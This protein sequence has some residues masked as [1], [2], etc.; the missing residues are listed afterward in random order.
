MRQEAHRIWHW[1]QWWA[2][3][4]KMPSGCQQFPQLLTDPTRESQHTIVLFPLH[5]TH[6]QSSWG[7]TGEQGTPSGLSIW[8]HPATSRCHNRAAHPPGGHCSRLGGKGETVRSKCASSWPCCQAW[9]VPLSWTL[10]MTEITPSI[11]QHRWSRCRASAFRKIQKLVHLGLTQKVWS[12]NTNSIC[13]E[14]QYKVTEWER[15]I[16]NSRWESTNDVIY[17]YIT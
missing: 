15:S 4:T 3:F 13:N 11:G 14:K 9:Y 8:R 6:P 10:W 17:I 2:P 12:E 16:G 1:Q 7:F 5:G